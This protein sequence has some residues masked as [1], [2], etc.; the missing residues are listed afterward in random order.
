MTLGQSFQAYA[1]SLR[2]EIER[3]MR[4]LGVSEIAELTPA[5]VTQL[6]STRRAE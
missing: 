3:T 4:L 1:S 6:N 2:N 5:H